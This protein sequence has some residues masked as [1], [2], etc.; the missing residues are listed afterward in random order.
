M[1]AY[2]IR[3]LLLIPL[4]LLGVTWLVFSVTRVAP[5]GPVQRL[6]Q[7]QAANG[8][9]GKSNSSHQQGGMS[10]EQ[11]EAM[12]E[13]FGV[14]KK[15]LIAYGQWLGVVAR[16]DN[17]S[18]REFSEAAEPL[19]DGAEAI[20]VVAKGT[21]RVVKVTR[22]GDQL[23]SAVFVD[24]G[25]KI[26]NAG[27]SARVESPAD[28]QDRWLRRQTDAD[29]KPPNYG[30]RAV[31]FKTNYSGLLQGDLRNSSTY[32]DPVIEMVFERVPIALYFG[33]LTALIT[34][35]VCIPLGILKA[36][37]HR[38]FVDNFS[39][40]L[41]FLGYSIPGFALGA[42]LLVYLGARAEIFPLFGLVSDNFSELSGLEKLL[43]L[44]HHTVLP[45]LCYVVGGFAGTTM[46]MKNNL[47]DNLAADYVRTAMAKGVSF[48]RAVFCH[49]LRNSMIPIATSIGG[50]L[51]IFVSGSILIETVFDINGFGLMQFQAITDKDMPVIM[52]TLTISAFLMLLGNVISDMVVA[53]VDP[54]IKFN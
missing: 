15:M 39:S 51:T 8:D 25:E 13:E 30:H 33:I 26:E 16:E 29:A 23:V 18:K 4:T 31:V 27:W 40:I 35:S 32:G 44:A 22:N 1:K 5:G 52:G 17:L 46:M 9:G 24:T 34:Y 20:D 45:L 14:D 49:A 43:D 7:E 47:M 48:K 3:R 11:V 37:K 53:M 12:E 6:L 42:V 36:I 19:A 41:I 21:D 2:F 38:T 54:R 10:D 28:R 50:L